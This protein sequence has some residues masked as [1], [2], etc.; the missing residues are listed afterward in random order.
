MV[1]QTTIIAN[2]DAVRRNAYQAAPEGRC[3]E[4]VTKIIDKFMVRG[5]NGPMQ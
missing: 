1:M 2:A 4:S 3:L 5:T